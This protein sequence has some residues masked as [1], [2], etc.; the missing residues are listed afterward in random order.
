LPIGACIASKEL[1]DQFSHDPILG[2]ITTFGGHPLICAGALAGLKE[3]SER[4]LID[5]VNSKGEL[6]FN[7][8]NSHPQVKEIRYRGLLFAIELDTDEAVQ[9]VVEDCLQNGVIGFYFLSHR[10][11][12]RLAPPFII[13]DDELKEAACIITN[14]LDKL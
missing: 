9:K 2:H 8:L 1:L 13:S 6:L 14:A 4:K 5:G 10:T 12:F 3:M 7:T 11:S